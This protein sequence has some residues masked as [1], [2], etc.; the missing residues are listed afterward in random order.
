MK[1]AVRSVPAG[2]G[3]LSRGIAKARSVPKASGL[4][5]TVTKTS[6]PLLA[7]KA[8]SSLSAQAKKVKMV[9]A[10]PDLPLPAFGFV[11]VCFCLDATGSM[12]SELAQAQR[13][14]V[15]IIHNLQNKVRSEGI[16]LRFAVVSYRDHP[17]QDHTYVTKFQDFSDEHDTVKYINSLTA[18]G[19]GDFPEAVHDGLETCCK[20]LSWAEVSGA[21]TLRYIFHVADAPPHGS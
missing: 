11:D 12:C 14:V 10:H 7:A 18:N 1:A 13:S 3:A 21:P 4:A 8:S 17:P 6:G 5:F 2:M 16:T 20:K 15:S 9:S 19:G